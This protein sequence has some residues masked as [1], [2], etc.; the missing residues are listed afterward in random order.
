MKPRLPLLLSV[1]L[2]L[3][4][5]GLLPILIS[6]FQLRSNEDALA[7]Q[8]GRT[9]MV[10]ASASAARVD[11]H[12][13]SL[14]A[15]AG[16]LATHP[17]FIEGPRSITSQELLRGTLQSH[18]S[19]VAVG[20]FSSTGEEVI[21]AQRQDLRQEISQIYAAPAGG[22]IEVVEGTSQ[23]W[24]RLRLGL[25]SSE[26]VGD[27]G[28]LILVADTAPLASMVSAKE[29]G[30]QAEVL[31]VSRNKQPIFGQVSL[32]G[33][34]AASVERAMT[35][36]ISAEA[37]HYED[38]QV[39]AMIVGYCQLERAPW[40]VLSRQSASIAEVA[41]V[42]IRRATRWSALAALLLTGIFSLGAYVS[43]IRPLR[44]LARAQ[45]EMLGSRVQGSEIEQLE[46]SF[47]SLQE[48]LEDSDDLNEV[49]LGRYQVDRLVGSGAMGSVFRGWDPKLQRPVALKTLR[50]NVEDI[51]REKLV[52]SLVS[53][54]KLSARFNHSNIV[55]VYDVADSGNS[56]FIAMEYVKG[57]SLDA[58]LWDRGTL[59]PEEVIPLGAA[60]A[61]ALAVAHSHGLVHHDVKPANVLLGG[62]HSI[63]VTDFGISQL[64]SSAI[65][66]GDV[67]CG[68]P[69]YLAPEALMGEGYTPQSDLFSLGLIL[70]EALV[71]KHPFFGR[72]I[73]ETMLN[74]IMEEAPSIESVV[75]GIPESLARLVDQ[76]LAKQSADRPADAETVAVTL[77]EMAVE[78]K[79]RWKPEGSTMQS[80]DAAAADDRTRTQLLSLPDRHAIKPA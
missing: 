66:V 12:L 6:F 55:T 32:D 72:N 58:Y 30:G 69:G 3:G 2:T 27:Q 8:V 23:K 13:E 1:V 62:D 20:V 51:D 73:K 76:L 9:H 14:F 39:G 34:P 63:K 48:R 38:A 7:S 77:E 17:V 18:P 45:Q 15:V 68:T 49:F 40:V 56:A 42:K 16:A 19:I 4:A 11:A 37:S 52:K 65:K 67:I 35:A 25:A 21:L 10:I 60:I 28:A 61:R 70:F 79:L 5:A 44:R 78:F 24:L 54:A 47:R 29:I 31:L 57:V 22:E 80:L 74:T 46:A 59:T 71:G 36:K 26:G 50:M 75:P 64:I 33:F 41:R 53:E 43:V